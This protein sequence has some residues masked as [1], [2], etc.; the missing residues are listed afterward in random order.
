M[1]LPLTSSLPVLAELYLIVRLLHSDE[2]QNDKNKS[3]MLSF[4]FRVVDE[5]AQNCREVTEAISGV[6]YSWAL[7]KMKF[8]FFAAHL[9]MQTAS[10]K[11]FLGAS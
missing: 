3:M 7:Q 11:V 9:S 8:C 4:T 2:A 10:E 6:I 1:S 5:V